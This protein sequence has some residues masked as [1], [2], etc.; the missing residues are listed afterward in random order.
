MPKGEANI[1]LLLLR[2]AWPNIRGTMFQHALFDVHPGNDVPLI[3]TKLLNI[4]KIH[5]NQ[6]VGKSECSIC[7]LNFSTEAYP[8][9]VGYKA[10]T[11]NVQ[12]QL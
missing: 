9:L 11:S 5:A 6:F 4:L 10:K 3:T 8:K 1:Y 7:R 2:I 12:V